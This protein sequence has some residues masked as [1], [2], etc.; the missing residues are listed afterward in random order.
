MIESPM[1]QELIDEAVREKMH[2]S[3]LEILEKRFGPVPPEVSAA[4]RLIHDEHR[5][6]A[7][8]GKAATCTDLDAFRAQLHL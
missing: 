2:W 5:L 1:V 3:T 7:L 6:E 4:V 8:V